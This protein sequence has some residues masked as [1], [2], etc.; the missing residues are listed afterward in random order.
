MVR[1]H[2][3]IWEG[4]QPMLRSSSCLCWRRVYFKH[5]PVRLLMFACNARNFLWLQPVAWIALRHA[6]GCW[7]VHWEN[8]SF[9]DLNSMRNIL[10]ARCTQ[11]Q[12]ASIGYSK[13]RHYDAAVVNS[14]KTTHREQRKGFCTGLKITPIH[15]LR[16]NCNRSSVATSNWELP[17]APMPNQVFNWLEQWHTWALRS[18]H[19]VLT[20]PISWTCCSGVLLFCFSAWTFQTLVCLSRI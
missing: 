16:I 7:A 2:T 6:W 12:F 18:E 17:C 5:P 3:K 9:S 14:L 13:T 19:P 8:M 1:A 20:S 10:S 11:S 15:C 4:L